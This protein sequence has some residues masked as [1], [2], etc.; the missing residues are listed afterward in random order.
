LYVYLLWD[1]LSS[2]FGG[3]AFLIVVVEGERS[4]VKGERGEDGGRKTED[5]RLKTDDRGRMTVDD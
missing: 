4:K 3:Q 2:S 1:A 5:G